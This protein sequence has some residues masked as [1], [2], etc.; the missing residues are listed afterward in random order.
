MPR[1]KRKEPPRTLLVMDTNVLWH[2]NKSLVVAT[3]FQEFWDAYADE[4]ALE[5]VLPHVVRGELLYQQTSSALRALERVNENMD[6]V[7]SVA[8][9]KYSHRISEGRVRRDVESRFDKWITTVGAEVEATPVNSIDWDSLIDAAIW[10]KPPF[11]E[12]PKNLQLEKGFRDALILETL[13]EL[14]KECGTAKSKLSSYTRLSC[15][16]SLEDFA[17]YLKL[18]KEELTSE[19]VKNIQSRAIEKFYS[20]G[21]PSSLFFRENLAERIHTVFSEEFKPPTLGLGGLGIIA[22]A[23]AI[24]EAT[25]PEQVW[26]T[27]ARFVRLEGPREYHWLNIVSFIQP[28]RYTGSTALFA[29]EDAEKIRLRKLPFYVHWKANVKS[30]GRF[31]DRIIDNIEF[32]EQSFEAPTQDESNRYGLSSIPN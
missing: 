25:A 6:R 24:W 32:G 26:S 16:E 1:I 2:K 8:D 17:A 5:V 21:D 4:F 29:A 20:D 27:Q 22:G 28:F 13:G 18:T 9:Q 11:S 7:S 10:R 31:H 23:G 19:F 3:E 12:D 30:D 15:Y 14:C